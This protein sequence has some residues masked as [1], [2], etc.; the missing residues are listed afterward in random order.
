MDDF[1][2]HIAAGEKC[3]SFLFGLETLNSAVLIYHPTMPKCV[4]YAIG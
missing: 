1:V 2:F 4:K 3:P